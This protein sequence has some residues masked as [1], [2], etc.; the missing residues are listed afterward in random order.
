MQ[1]P[2]EAARKFSLEAG[3]PEWQANAG[4]QIQKLIDSSNP[5]VSSGN[6]KAFTEITGEQP[7][8]LKKWLAKYVGD[9]Q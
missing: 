7:T 4:L 9:F 3:V 5:V 8:D 1:V 6:V 2:Y